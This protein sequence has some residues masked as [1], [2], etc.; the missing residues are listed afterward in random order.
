MVSFFISTHPSI[1][2]WHSNKDNG[3]FSSQSISQTLVRCPW[4]PRCPNGNIYCEDICMGTLCPENVGRYYY[5][6]SNILGTGNMPCTYISSSAKHN[7][8]KWCLVSALWFIM[9]FPMH[10]Q[11]HQDELRVLLKNFDE[12]VVAD[13][14]Q[15]YSISSSVLITNPT[16]GAIISLPPSSPLLGSSLP[17]ISQTPPTISESAKVDIKKTVK[18]YIYLTVGTHWSI[19]H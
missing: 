16:P 15:W 13:C 18:I 6:V 7:L 12:W 11:E 5:Y 9:Y 2:I 1:I 17:E 4:I 19:T 14:L 8:E 10:S 3:W